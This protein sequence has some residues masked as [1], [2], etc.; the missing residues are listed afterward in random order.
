[1]LTNV[2]RNSSESNEKNRKF[3]KKNSKAFFIFICHEKKVV[4]WKPFAWGF[5]SKGLRMPF[6]QT[7]NKLS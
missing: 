6:F 7:L 2:R 5:Y 3:K 1:M 4:F